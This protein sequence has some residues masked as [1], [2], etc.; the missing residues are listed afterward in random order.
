MFAKIARQAER[1][2][3]DPQLRGHPMFSAQ[4]RVY[5]DKAFQKRCRCCICEPRCVIGGRCSDGCACAAENR[6]EKERVKLR[7]RVTA[8]AERSTRVL[9]NKYRGAGGGSA[10]AQDADGQDGDEPDGPDGDAS[11]APLPPPPQAQPPP[12][13]EPEDSDTDEA[14][15]AVIDTVDDMSDGGSEDEQ[16]EQLD[17]RN[18]F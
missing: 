2:L 9:H 6:H 5:L 4:N 11:D 1:Q 8:H 7:E 15:H 10:S 17:P 16:H 14:A 18:R 13:A 3:M 12:S